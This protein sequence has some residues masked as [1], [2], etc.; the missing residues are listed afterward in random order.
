MKYLKDNMRCNLFPSQFSN[1]CRDFTPSGPP[2]PSS[3]SEIFLCSYLDMALA[4]YS[5]LYGKNPETKD[6]QNLNSNVLCSVLW[7]EVTRIRHLT[8]ND[9]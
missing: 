9:L 7:S 6:K 3:L 8:N 1:S 4:M 5:V 2:E